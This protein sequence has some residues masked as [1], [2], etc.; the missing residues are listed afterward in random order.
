MF[1]GRHLDVTLRLATGTLRAEVP[2]DTPVVEG[3]TVP[4]GVKARDVHFVR[5]D[6]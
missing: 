3:V 5:T 2:I 6:S 1:L 4:V